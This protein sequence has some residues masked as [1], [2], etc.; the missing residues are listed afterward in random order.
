MIP[1]IENILTMFSKGECTMDEALQWIGSHIDLATDREALRDTFASMAAIGR[2]SDGNLLTASV[3]AVMGAPRPADDLSKADA[4]MWW[5]QAEARIRYAK[6]EA[7][8]AA[9][10][11]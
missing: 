2:D 11:L 5:C 1:D 4:F 9:R 6:A 7:M 8:L 10:C 3:V